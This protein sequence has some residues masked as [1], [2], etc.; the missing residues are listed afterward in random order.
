LGIL[1]EHITG[2]SAMI[3]VKPWISLPYDTTAPVIEF[4]VFEPTR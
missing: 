3:K 4:G 2:L 1:K